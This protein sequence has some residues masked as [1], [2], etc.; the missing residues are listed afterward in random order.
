MVLLNR[1]LN[2][3]LFVT[4]FVALVFGVILFQRRGDLRDR[5]EKLAD[6]LSDIVKELDEKSGTK[7]RLE[8]NRSERTGKDGKIQP[9]GTLGWAFF[10]EAYDA[11][12]KTHPDFD[13]LLSE[14]E[15]Q[16]R[17]VREQRDNLAVAVAEIANTFEKGGKEPTAYLHLSSY[18]ENTQ[19]VLKDM[20]DVKNRDDIMVA[21]IE[22]TANKIGYPIDKGV[23]VDSQKFEEPLT[24][25]GNQVG[26]LKERAVNYA[27]AL[28][29]AVEKIDSHPFAANAE[30]LKDADAYVGELTAILNDFTNINDKLSDY[31]KYKIEFLETKDTLEKT[32]AALEK[33]HENLAV[34]ENKFSRIE[35]ENVSLKQKYSEIAGERTQEQSTELQKLE[36]QVLD[37]DYDWNYV[38]LNLG[39]K[40]NLP[41]N[42]EMTVAREQEYICKV[43][44]TKV[45][46]N[47]S[48]AE[49][50]PKLKL[51]SVIEGD[52]VLF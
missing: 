32:I 9:G 20:T 12:T 30:G 18:E 33:S 8:A 15:K 21:K 43:L 16:V 48:V 25:F 19:S 22:E 52:R 34:M 36:G 4:A 26:K 23:L 5:G 24:N 42:L 38:V 50:L 28:A 27:D 31:E 35:T 47:Y 10:H 40:D 11:D 17:D 45:Y 39:E 13:N 37:V 3:L 44:V 46:K 41:E 2:I 6:T 14:V 29:Q 51:G 1:V 7:L 49:I